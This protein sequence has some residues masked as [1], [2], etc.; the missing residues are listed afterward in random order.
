MPRGRRE[1]TDV[2]ARTIVALAREW[3]S[4]R[5]CLAGGTKG[6]EG[7]YC[8]QAYA[9]EHAR[10][11]VL[12]QAMQGLGKP[13]VAIWGTANGPPYNH[14]LDFP[15]YASGACFNLMA[16]KPVMNPVKQRLYRLTAPD[17]IL[18]PPLHW[19]GEGFCGNKLEQQ[20]T[21]FDYPMPGYNEVKMFYRYGGAFLST[22][23]ETNR[24]VRMYQSPKLEFVVNQDCWFSTETRLADVI[25][26]AC[27]NLERDDIS[28]YASS[29]GYSLHASGSANHRIIIYQQKC[30][31]PVGES[32]S[33]YEIF[34]GLAEKLGVLDDYTE[35][36]TWHQ[37]IEK[38]FYKS[39]LPKY[40]AFDDFKKKGYFVVPQIED[41]KPTPAL[42][43]YYEDRECDTPDFGNPKRNTAKAKDL[44]T[45]SGKIEFVSESLKANTPDDQERPPLPKYIPSWEGHESEAF[46][47]Y[48]DRS[49]LAAPAVHLP[50]PP[51]P[52][53]AVALGDPGAPHAQRRLRLLGGA[54]AS[55][56]TPTPGA[57]ST[58][59]SS[60][61]TT[62]GRRC[63]AWRTSPRG[64][65]REWSTPTKA[66]PATTPSSRARPGPPTG[67]AA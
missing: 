25:L 20:F 37:W 44:G 56:A 14:T 29:G 60:S 4:H 35:G 52:S 34:C 58:A 61:C 28:E 66:R 53:R 40:V 6:G 16:E 36:N 18:E 45:Y 51:R 54:R 21:E 8:R 10:M 62:T 59:T 23:T 42:R 30:V 19:M 13:G 27:T 67:A 38:M 9:T 11:L 3:A 57:S 63:C 5:T 1:V 32:K 17:A 12:L 7:G 2:P 64:F 48:P 43:W 39:D 65:V 33:D 22:M 49:H 47:K 31:E 15:G 41:Y 24:W 55:R 46:K 26:P 50:H